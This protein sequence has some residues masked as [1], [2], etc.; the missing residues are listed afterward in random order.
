MTRM[1]APRVVGEPS[2]VVGGVDCH[3]DVHVVAALDCVGRR[4]G[5]AEFPATSQGY[6]DLEDWLRQHGPISAVGVE[7]TS[8]YGA[9]LTRQLHAAGMRVV[10]VNQPHPHA[11]SRRGKTDVIDAEMAARKVLSG[12]VTTVPKDTTGVVE[13]IRQLKVARGGA[14][15]ARAAALVTLGEL[16]ITAPAELREQ[17]NARSL[18][19]RAAQAGRLRPDSTRLADPLQAAKLALR[20][21]ARQINDLD[22]TIA[23][24]DAA[25]TTLVATAAPRTLGLLGVGTQHAAQLLLAMGQNAHRLRDEAAFAHLCG[26]SPIPASSGKTVRHRLNRGGDRAANRSLHMITVV[27]LRYCQRTQAYLQRRLSDGKTKREA[28]RCLK[29]YIARQVYGTLT[30]D[31]NDLAATS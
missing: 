7:S 5:H 20:N 30:A 31:L 19:G 6:R 1:T 4:P 28:M 18:P 25:L 9:A 12:E 16:L 24:L 26:A 15:K 2:T 23:E 17:L 22:G 3:A 8:G 27:R 11:R 14:V 13:S 29:R 10:E 21:L